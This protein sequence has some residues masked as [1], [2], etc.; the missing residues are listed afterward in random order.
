MRTKKAVQTMVL[1]QLKKLKL[2]MMT[3]VER[4]ARRLKPLREERHW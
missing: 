2:P 4:A 3:G 1:M